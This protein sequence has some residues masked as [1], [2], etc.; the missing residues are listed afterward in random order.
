[1]PKRLRIARSATVA[2][3]ATMALTAT[4]CAS[5][6]SAAAAPPFTTIDVVE[7]DW[8]TDVC[9]RTRDADA[10]LMRLATNRGYEGS[11]F[12]CFGFGDRHYLISRER[13][14][15]T[16]LSALL[17]GDGAILLTMLRDTPTA[18][19]G[20]E[21]TV[22]LAVDAPGMDRLR[23]FLNQAVQTDD[24]GAPVWLADGPYPGGLY[25]GATARYNGLYT[26]NTWTADA[27]RQA[28]LP[29]V[30]PIL[31]AE[32]VMRQVRNLAARADASVEGPASRSDGSAGEAAP[33]R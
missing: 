30:G 32:G 26:C 28:G 14:P 7:R 24:A 1:M 29:L 22:R 19:F 21:N 3:V 23:R 27:L 20:A 33:G 15:L 11:H 25:F 17:P 6:P 2:T 9:I 31:F 13:G 16:L 18:A 4:G 8:H 5:A 12:L 10:S